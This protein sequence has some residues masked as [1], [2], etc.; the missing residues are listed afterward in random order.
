MKSSGYSK[1]E[2]LFSAATQAANVLKLSDA[3][4]SVVLGVDVESLADWRE[5]MLGMSPDSAPYQN[6]VTFLRV[7][8][9]LSSIV[10]SDPKHLCGWFNAYNR[11]LEGVPAELVKSQEGLAS[12]A[13]YLDGHRD[14][15]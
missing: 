13:D 10:G 7:A 1:A 14:Y 4:F 3:E 9:S 2:V 5:N 6:A 15:I 8:Q 11:D 12:V